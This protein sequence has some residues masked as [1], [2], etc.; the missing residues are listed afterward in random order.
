MTSLWRHVTIAWPTLNLSFV[1]TVWYLR[2][3]HSGQIVFKQVF[4]GTMQT[5]TIKDRVLGTLH[6]FHGKWYLSSPPPPHP[7]DNVDFEPS[8]L[9]TV[10]QHCFRGK[11]GSENGI[12]PSHYKLVCQ[13]AVFSLVFQGIL[14]LIVANSPICKGYMPYCGVKSSLGVHFPSPYFNKIQ[15]QIKMW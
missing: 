13:C 12:M 1:Y 5:N 9:A 10:F 15:L 3:S 11:G 8:S 4:S 6:C 7:Y 2:R 14:S